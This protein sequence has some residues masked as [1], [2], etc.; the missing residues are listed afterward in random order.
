MATAKASAMS[1]D[2]RE[3]SRDVGPRSRS[4]QSVKL[5]RQLRQR[6]RLWAAFLDQEISEVVE[7][8][9]TKHLDH[10]ERQ[11]AERNLPPLPIPDVDTQ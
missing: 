1:H 8:A 6:L 4:H 7:E 3:V 5:P 11:R 9:L 10:L 2:V